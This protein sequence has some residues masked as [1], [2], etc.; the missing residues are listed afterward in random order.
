MLLV[1]RCNTSTDIEID[2]NRMFQPSVSPVFSDLIFNFL[3]SI[4]VLYDFFSKI[5]ICFC[6]SL[7]S[8]TGLAQMTTAV[9]SSCDH[10]VVCSIK[11]VIMERDSYPRRWGL[12]PKALEKKQLIKDGKLDKYGRPL[13]AAKVAAAAAP[14]A[15]AAAAPAAAAPA[16][17]EAVASKSE[18]RKK[19]DDS[20]SDSEKPKKEKKE[21]KK[22]KVDLFFVPK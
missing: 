10:G 1:S 6:F 15:A 3:Y 13:K 8:A 22:S 21:K 19:G 16:P 18:K 7:L 11:R 14:A 2:F 17:L 20:A 9:M 4:I 5:R 12:G